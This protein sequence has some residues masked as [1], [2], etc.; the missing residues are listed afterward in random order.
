MPAAIWPH[1]AFAQSSKPF[2]Q[3]SSQGYVPVS[4]ARF[5]HGFLPMPCVHMLGSIAV[6]LQIRLS[7]A[8]VANAVFVASVCKWRRWT[9]IAIDITTRV[10]VVGGRAARRQDDRKRRNEPRYFLCGHHT[11]SLFAALRQHVGRRVDWR[12]QC[13]GKETFNRCTTRPRPP[14]RPRRGIED[15]E[16]DEDEGVKKH[17]NNFSILRE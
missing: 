16:E 12:W 15:E 7:Y 2:M 13:L 9:V 5:I 17:Q 4:P 10:T 1:S 8:G 6:N 11:C 3:S 14:P